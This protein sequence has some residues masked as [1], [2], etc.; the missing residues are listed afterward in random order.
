MPWC[1]WCQR[2]S[3]SA[4]GD[5]AAAQVDDRLEVDDELVLGDRAG[6]LAAERQAADVGGVAGVRV[7]GGPLAG[8]FR[9]VHGHVGA[10]QQLGDAAAAGA[11][12]DAAAGLDAD[13]HA[14]DLDRSCRAASSGVGAM[15]GDR[16]GGQA[17][18][19]YRELVAAEAGDQVAGVGGRLAAG[20]RPARSTSSPAACPSVSLTSLKW[21]RSISSR[22]M[23]A[24][25]VAAARVIS[26][27]WS[28][29]SRRLA[30]PVSGSCVAAY[31]FSPAI[32]ASSAY[33]GAL[34]MAV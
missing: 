28:S 15:R 5:L 7:G 12:G 25:A 13:L 3:A 27:P 17:G 30:R 22:A 33:A 23:H 29:R 26:L 2:A 4:R 11:A 14:L 24:V 32:R 10:A 31:A 6:Q 9:L 34:R 16:R 19:Q 21:L 1:G 20:R 18:E 8:A